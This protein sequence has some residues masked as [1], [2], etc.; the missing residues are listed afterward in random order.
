MTVCRMDDADNISGQ[1][2][3]RKPGAFVKGIVLTA[4][5]FFIALIV[6]GF[7]AME[8]STGMK[9]AAAGLWILFVLSFVNIY[10]SQKR[11]DRYFTAYVFNDDINSA[12]VAE[13]ILRACTNQ[14]LFGAEYS[15]TFG[16][17]HNNWGRI[18]SN[19]KYIDTSSKVDEFLAR[20]DVINYCGS[21]IEEVHDISETGKEY[22]VKAR[23]R[24]LDTRHF[25]I[26][27][28]TGTLRI[29]KNFYNAAALIDRLEM[30]R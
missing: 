9:L 22:R 19:M 24:R 2:L 18:A 1:L 7:A 4:V 29:P 10:L 5:L 8:E 20:R 6:S 15:V 16:R 3:S 13:D 12:V 30:M 28:Y 11:A 25:I 14:T 26:N 21:V 23:L 27:N 17:E